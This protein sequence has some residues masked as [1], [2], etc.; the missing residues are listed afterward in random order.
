VVCPR[1]TKVVEIFYSGRF[2]WPAKH[3]L[4]ISF[5]NTINELASLKPSRHDFRLV[6]GA[7]K[8]TQGPVMTNNL[9]LLRKMAVGAGLVASAFGF[10]A[11]NA[12]A[13]SLPEVSNCGYPDQLANLMCWSPSTDPSVKIYVASQ[14]D[15][16][17]SY[18]ANILHTLAKTYKYTE[19]SDWENLPSFGSGQIIKLFSY[20]NSQ[21]D[22]PFPDSNEGTGDTGNANELPPY[23]A[24]DDQTAPADE[25]YV[26]TWP[27]F[28]TVTIGEL[29][30]FMQGTGAT[31]PVFAFDF[32]NNDPLLV[33]GYFEVTG[34]NGDIFSFDNV[35][36]SAYDVASLVLV[37]KTL[38]ISW[39]DIN[40]CPANTGDANPAN[41]Y[42]C[43]M[44]VDNDVGG[45]KPDFFT[46][47]TT[48]N[49][50][51]DKWLDT[52]TVNF[53]LRMSGL[54]S[55]GEELALVAIGTPRDTPPVIPEPGILALLGLGLLG[56]GLA[57]K[58]SGFRR[59]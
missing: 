15:D 47:A 50:F 57:R 56:L 36:N 39:K 2:L 13:L 14:H 21:N 53:H 38:T 12:L 9:K 48:F 18:G 54:D 30:T 8:F 42:V 6:I 59:S 3:C 45:G 52:D 55:A 26:G 51:D 23:D 58:S 27:A 34:A 10:S 35:F 7:Y 49:I 31:S 1:F 4:S 40:K 29:R 16:F 17:I 11:G 24:D 19:L 33:N 20:N 25:N 5:I 44:V 22:D 43:T 37:Q 41:D 28:E 32:T 46:Y